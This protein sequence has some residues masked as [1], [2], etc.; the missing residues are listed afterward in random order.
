[1]IGLQLKFLLESGMEKM[2]QDIFVHR[3]L[4]RICSGL[5]LATLVIFIVLL[6][7]PTVPPATFVCRI[8][9]TIVPGWA[10]ASAS[11]TTVL[12]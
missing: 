10:P 2:I 4:G 3:L 11:A 6:A 9:I 1:M 7:L 12:F 5:K 8:L